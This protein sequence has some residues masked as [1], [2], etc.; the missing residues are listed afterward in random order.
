[1]KYM[2]LHFLSEKNTAESR[3]NRNDRKNQ[4]YIQKDKYTL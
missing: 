3:K 2:Q 4:Y 1:M